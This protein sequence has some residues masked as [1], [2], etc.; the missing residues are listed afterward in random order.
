MWAAFSNVQFCQTSGLFSLLPAI[1]NCKGFSMCAACTQ[2][3]LVCHHCPRNLNIQPTTPGSWGRVYLFSYGSFH[4]FCFLM[5]HFTLLSFCFLMAHFTFFL[6]GHFTLLFIFDPSLYL[7][8]F[9]F[10]VKAV[11]QTQSACIRVERCFLWSTPPPTG[12]EGGFKL[13]TL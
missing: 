8:P 1:L 12:V 2:V 4:S 3:L 7:I 13:V 6:M 11:K 5:P 10:A 9:S